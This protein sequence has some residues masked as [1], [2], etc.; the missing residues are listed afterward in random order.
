MAAV[1]V[2]TA[3]PVR[4]LMLVQDP[5]SLLTIS[6]KCSKLCLISLTKA[7]STTGRMKKR[8]TGFDG[9]YESDSAW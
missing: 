4:A 6:L 3:N 5:T 9:A 1:D 2:V 8:M 7:M